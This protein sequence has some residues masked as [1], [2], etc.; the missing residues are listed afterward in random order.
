MESPDWLTPAQAGRRLGLT[1]GYMRQLADSGRVRAQR[2]PLGRLLDAADVERLRR[3]RA[4]HAAATD[5][6]GAR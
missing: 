1:A 6:H 2:T 5:V 4:D 3:E